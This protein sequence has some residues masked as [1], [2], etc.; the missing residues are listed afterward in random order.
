M[1]YPAEIYITRSLLKEERFHGER[2]LLSLSVTFEKNRMEAPETGC[3]H[4]RPPFSFYA[5]A[6]LKYRPGLT[7]RFNFGRSAAFGL[8]LVT[9]GLQK[10]YP[11]RVHTRKIR[12]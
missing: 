11:V 10:D 5:K 3:F 9:V 1:R 6:S 12:D 4:F 2:K 7:F 8:V